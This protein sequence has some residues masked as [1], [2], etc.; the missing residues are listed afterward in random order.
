MAWPKNKIKCSFNE[1]TPSPCTGALAFLGS[2]LPRTVQR[3]KKQQGT[4]EA[5][6]MPS[7]SS[8]HWTSVSPVNALA[9]VFPAGMTPQVLDS[10]TLSSVPHLSHGSS[11]MR[12]SGLGPS[13]PR[14]LPRAIYSGGLRASSQSRIKAHCPYWLDIH[15]N[16]LHSLQELSP[17]PSLFPVPPRYNLFPGLL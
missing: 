6:Y 11:A 10:Q 2:H 13:F 14:H 3:S 7:T 15:T 17:K 4:G 16:P 5:S 9:P 1:P 12:A 8:H